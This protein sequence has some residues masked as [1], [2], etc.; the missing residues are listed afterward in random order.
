MYIY[1]LYG[2]DTV[3][4]HSKKQLAVLTIGCVYHT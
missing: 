4:L 1:G 3:A 2:L